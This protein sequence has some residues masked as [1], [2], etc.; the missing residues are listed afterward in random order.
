[1]SPERERLTNALLLS[2]LI[3]M[4]VLSLIFGGQGLWRPGFGFPW[5]V[6]RIEAPD[7]RVVVVPPQVTAAEPAVTPVAE[8]LPQASVERPVASAPAPTPPVS[9]APTPR[10]TEAAIRPEANPR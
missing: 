2:L 4:W 3:H 7:L 10:R 9:R 5:Q 6:R 1:M 8:P